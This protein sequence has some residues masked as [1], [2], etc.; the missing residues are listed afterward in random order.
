MWCYQ[1]QPNAISYI[2]AISVVGRCVGCWQLQQ[3]MIQCRVALD[4]ATFT[5]AS[6]VFDQETQGPLVGCFIHLL[7]LF[8]T[9]C[10]EADAKASDAYTLQLFD[11]AHAWS[12]GRLKHVLYQRQ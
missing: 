12:P 2:A 9:Y 8:G 11:D 5:A 6:R 1:L 4:A 3:Q 7:R 10:P